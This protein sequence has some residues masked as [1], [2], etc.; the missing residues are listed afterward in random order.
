M[1]GKS[2]LF[3]GGDLR[4]LYCAKHMAK[5][6][7]EVSVFGFEKS[8][9]RFCELVN[10][11]SLRVA[12]SLADYIVLPLPVTFDNIY[13]NMS[14]S[15]KE[16]KL[17][18]LSSLIGKNQVVLYGNA[19]ENVE[20]IFT[21]KG[22]KTIDYFK[23]EI[24]TLKNAVFTAEGA[25]KTAQSITDRCFYNSAV[26]ITGFGRIGEYLARLLKAYNA[27]VTVAVR[28]KEVMQKVKMNGLK[29]INLRDICYG[30]D[31]Y[32][33]IFNTVDKE[34]FD[35][36]ILKELDENAILI[37]LAS[38]SGFN[39][40]SCENMGLKLKT[41]RGLPGKCFAQSAGEAVAQ[42]LINIIGENRNEKY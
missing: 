21:D 2:V 28:R 13:L 23:D 1:C 6:G 40:V 42:S 25:V 36:H 29:A 31:S 19:K 41:A 33:F 4:C 20:K 35:F 34:V 26:L 38:E 22:I 37:D 27:D 3:I 10:F 7:F 24:L 18:K 11:S 15:D 32:D 14:L 12:L 8:S 9:V 39:K 16:L 30:A 5:A 17:S